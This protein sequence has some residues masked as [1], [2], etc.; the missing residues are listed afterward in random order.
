MTVSTP[1]AIKQGALLV[2]SAQTEKQIA[3]LQQPYEPLSTLLIYS[4]VALREEPDIKSLYN[5]L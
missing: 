1:L 4:L 3:V 2:S 5:L